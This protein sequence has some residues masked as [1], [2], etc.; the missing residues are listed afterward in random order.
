[1]YKCSEVE[2][3]LNYIWKKKKSV[4]LFI[5][6]DREFLPAGFGVS[7]QAAKCNK[8]GVT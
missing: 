8:Y 5:L 1:M 7:S 6:A 2:V 3:L 4:S